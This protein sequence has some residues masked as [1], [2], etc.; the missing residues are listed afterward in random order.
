MDS[1]GGSCGERGLGG[2]QLPEQGWWV[3]GW[4]CGVLELLVGAD[5]SLAASAGC[6]QWPGAPTLP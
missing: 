5:W 1:P 6:T 4:G 3:V 2:P